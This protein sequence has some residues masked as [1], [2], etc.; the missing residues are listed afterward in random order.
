MGLEHEA[1]GEPQSLFREPP[2]AFLPSLCEALSPGFRD[3]I[4]SPKKAAK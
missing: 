4:S 3:T 2:P 1:L